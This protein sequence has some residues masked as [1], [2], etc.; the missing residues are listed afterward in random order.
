MRIGLGLDIGSIANRGG[1]PN[2][3]QQ[4]KRCIQECNKCRDVCR[5]TIDYCQEQAGELL[6]IIPVLEDCAD[7]C[8][9][10]P[11]FLNR[12]SIFYKEVCSLC[13]EVCERTAQECRQFDKDKTLQKCAESCTQCALACRAVTNLG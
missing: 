2:K 7:I 8:E 3:K 13:A 1:S 4:I 5:Q 9:I 6:R 10:V 11:N 12:D